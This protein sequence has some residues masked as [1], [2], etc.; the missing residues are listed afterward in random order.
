[1]STLSH[2]VLPG[3]D[4]PFPRSRVMRHEFGVIPCVLDLSLDVLGFVS[5]RQPEHS[6]LA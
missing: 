5:L 1:M 6:I 3:S 2:L 4:R